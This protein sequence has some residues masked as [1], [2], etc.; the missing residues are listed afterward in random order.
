[1]TPECRPACHRLDAL[2]VVAVGDVPAEPE[3]TSAAQAGAA[4]TSQGRHTVGATYEAVD[5]PATGGRF[6]VV[7]EGAVF[8][9]C[10]V[11]K[12]DGDGDG[13]T[14]ALYDPDGETTRSVAVVFTKPEAARLV[15]AIVEKADLR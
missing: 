4:P 5:I 6:S 9:R 8:P 12:A 1:M 15:A 10:E 7:D 13:V 3:R 14:L 2:Y 11:A